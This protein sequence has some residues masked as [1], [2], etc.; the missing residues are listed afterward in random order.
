MDN[1]NLIRAVVEKFFHKR[2]CVFAGFQ[3]GVK[4][5]KIFIEDVQLKMRMVQYAIATCNSQSVLLNPFYFELRKFFEKLYYSMDNFFSEIFM[6]SL[7]GLLSEK[8]IRMF[9]LKRLV[10]QSKS[11]MLGENMYKIVLKSLILGENMYAI[12]LNSLILGKNMHAI[13]LNSL[14]HGRKSLLHGENMYTI[15]LNSLMHGR[16]SLLHGIEISAIERHNN[17]FDNYHQ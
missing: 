6:H 9:G 13:V 1:Q 14:M 16:K 7:K 15:V 3:S 11:L 10:L 17:I 8:N 12:V 2:A 5:E 4:T